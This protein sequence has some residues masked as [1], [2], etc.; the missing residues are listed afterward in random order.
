M[1]LEKSVFLKN[2][3]FLCLSYGRD[4]DDAWHDRARKWLTNRL[5]E[6]GKDLRVV[7]LLQV[8]KPLCSFPFFIL[9]AKRFL[10]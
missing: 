3:E 1:S 8:K 6:S 10:I 9:E 7:E 5:N 2:L 4:M